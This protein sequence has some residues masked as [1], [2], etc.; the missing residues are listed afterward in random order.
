MMQLYIYNG[1]ITTYYIT[2]NGS[3]YN[4]KTKKW[5]KGQV[6][7]NGYRTYQIS[8]DGE[9]K[10][11]YAH[12]MVAETYLP[13]IEGKTQV[14]HKDGN[15]L[16]N[17][18]ENLEWVN[19]SENAIHT[20]KTW[21]RIDGLHP[22]YCFD[23]NKKLVCIYPTIADACAINHYNAST[24]WKRLNETK[25]VMSYGFY[26]ANNNDNTFEILPITG[27]KKKVGQYN[28]QGEIIATYESRNECA[29]ITGY[30]KKRIGECCNGKIKTYHGYTFKYLDEDIV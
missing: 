24:L 1:Q 8:I 11:L 6:S 15:K 4:E 29:R 14:N 12:R 16:N 3:L 26:W 22:V 19:A 27:V 13:K 10:R 2:T 5:L 17:E 7:K 25:K 18:V 21:L 9:K 20:V 28:A 30:D 23:K